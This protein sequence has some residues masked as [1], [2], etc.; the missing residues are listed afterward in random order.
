[1]VGQEPGGA[2]DTSG[3]AARS[4]ARKRPIDA[5]LLDPRCAEVCNAAQGRLAW[6]DCIS[7]TEWLQSG[8]CVLL[9]ARQG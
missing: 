1:M 6:V 5:T 3:H 8:A 2:G 7:G 4:G 9:L